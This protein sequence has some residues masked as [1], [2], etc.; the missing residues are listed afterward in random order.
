MFKSTSIFILFCL[1]TPLYTGC[2]NALEAHLLEV[3]RLSKLRSA[4]KELLDYQQ[5]IIDTV[6]KYH[7]ERQERSER[8]AAMWAKNVKHHRGQL[9]LIEKS[10]DRYLKSQI[11]FEMDGL[12]RNKQRHRET[13]ETL[14]TDERLYIQ[15]MKKLRTDLKV[16]R[17][18]YD[19]IY[20]L[21]QEAVF[22]LSKLKGL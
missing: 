6:Q 8:T 19:S 17:T 12:N 7:K 10:N 16:I 2:D 4:T 11:P 13:L 15:K 14:E 3:D 18:A 22:K 1:T 21:H 5:A 9:K 20:A